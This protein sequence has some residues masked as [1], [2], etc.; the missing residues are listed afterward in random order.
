MDLFPADIPQEEEAGERLSAARSRGRVGGGGHPSTP[1]AGN[2]QQD[3]W[4]WVGSCPAQTFLKKCI[5][6][7][8]MGLKWRLLEKTLIE[9][10]ITVIFAGSLP[11]L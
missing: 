11:V 8:F 4:L 5:V 1:Q 6:F 7:P 10:K 3:P 9:Q 2:R